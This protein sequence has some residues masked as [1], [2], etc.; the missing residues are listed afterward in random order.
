MQEKAM[1]GIGQP[2]VVTRL[3]M[4]AFG[5]YAQIVDHYFRLEHPTV[6]CVRG[7]TLPRHHQEAWK[8]AVIAVQTAIHNHEV[9]A[10][11]GTRAEAAL[12][13]EQGRLHE[14]ETTVE[15]RG[16]RYGYV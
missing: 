6:R 4:E 15:K 2:D 10:W 13:D 11:E 1:R 14:A 5:A 16:G 9:L 12:V 7:E 8:H 3:A